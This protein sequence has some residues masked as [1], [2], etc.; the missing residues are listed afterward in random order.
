[1]DAANF[2][3]ETPLGP[4]WGYIGEQGLQALLLPNPDEAPPRLHFLHSA[5]NVVLGRALR[6]AFEG[7]FAGMPQSFAHITVDL[8]HA[9][10]FRQRVWNTTRDIPWGATVTY[11]K[12]AQMS[13]GQSG[14]ARAIGQAMG[15]NPVPIVIPCHRV[16]AAG[17]GLGGFSAGIPW[18][19]LLLQLEGIFPADKME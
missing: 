12:L 18:K 17:G 13:G 7:Y 9:T 10:P 8:R 4:I 3:F 6:Q 14:A 2:R 16:L 1:M 5:P 19:R 15:A 11:A